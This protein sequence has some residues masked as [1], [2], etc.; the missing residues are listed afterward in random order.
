M[1]NVSLQLSVEIIELFEAASVDVCWEVV[2]IIVGDL[3]KK[4]GRS[5]SYSR[6]YINII[7]CRACS[8]S[9]YFKRFVNARHF[10][11]SDLQ[12][13]LIVK[14]KNTEEDF[15]YPFEIT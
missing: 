1:E 5:S 13:K 15:L 6:F 10:N 14:K 11:N 3:R 9:N 4:V 12:M 2:E 8:C 7:C